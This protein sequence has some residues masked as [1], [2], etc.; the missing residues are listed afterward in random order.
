MPVVVRVEL[1]DEN[2]DVAAGEVLAVV[3]QFLLDAAAMDASNFVRGEDVLDGLE[4]FAAVGVAPQG[5]T[6]LLEDAPSNAGRQVQLE[7]DRRCLVVQGSVHGFV[8]EVVERLVFVEVLPRLVI[9]RVDA[10]EFVGRPVVVED[11]GGDLL[12]EFVQPSV[13]VVVSV[14]QSERKGEVVSHRRSPRFRRH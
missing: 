10:V 13:C 8:I 11:V 1:V 7:V 6:D 5:S 9:G 3:P 14:R 4:G 12:D 2:V